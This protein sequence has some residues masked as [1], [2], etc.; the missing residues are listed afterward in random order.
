MNTAANLFGEL[1]KNA[2]QWHTPATLT[3]AP[4]NDPGRGEGD[5]V[6]EGEQGNFHDTN[7]PCVESPANMANYQRVAGAMGGFPGDLTR[8][9]LIA[10]N[11]KL[12]TDSAAVLAENDALKKQ[13]KVLKTGFIQ[14]V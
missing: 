2:N 1:S 11:T 8:I 9:E 10:A 14:P 4:P 5:G 7:Y 12:T 3:V 6:G 13:I